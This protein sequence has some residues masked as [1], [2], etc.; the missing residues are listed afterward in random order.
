[1]STNFGTQASGQSGPGTP[2]NDTDDSSNPGVV[3]EF[4]SVIKSENG[5]R[6]DGQEGQEQKPKF[7]EI[8]ETPKPPVHSSKKR[9]EAEH[10]QTKMIEIMDK[11][12]EIDLVFQAFAKRI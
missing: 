7:R 11:D 3:A 6:G 9:K 4:G 1:M 12:D 5:G 2:E 10:L 8:E